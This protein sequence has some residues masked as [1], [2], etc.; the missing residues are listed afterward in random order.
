MR[1]RHDGC[2]GRAAECADEYDHLVALG[3]FLGR[4][5][6]V[7]RLALAVLNH[8][9][10]LLAEYAALGVDF[11]ERELDT[12]NVGRAVVSDRTGERLDDTDLHGVLGVCRSG[13][14][15]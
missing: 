7:G 2:R 8:E 14:Q 1:D 10:D 11:A 3:Q 9:F 5:D 13:Q 15:D 6:G 4:V 12:V